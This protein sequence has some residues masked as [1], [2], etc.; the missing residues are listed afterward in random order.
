MFIWKVTFIDPHEGTVLAWSATKDQA[1]VAA[2][3]L[4][5]QYPEGNLYEVEK[6]WVPKTRATL[7]AWLNQN[8]TRAND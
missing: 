8:F 6:V 4:E 5:A 3:K 1:H 2:F 7:A